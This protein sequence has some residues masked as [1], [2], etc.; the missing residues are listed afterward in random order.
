MQKLINAISL[1]A[2]LVAGMNVAIAGYLY[3]NKD[4]IFSDIKSM[5]SEE[6]KKTVTDALPGIMDDAMP[7]P[8][9]FP[10]QTGGVIP[11]I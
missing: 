7:E 5:A 6:I 2:G 3:L 8:P 11:G 9:E 10:K 1:F 4:Y